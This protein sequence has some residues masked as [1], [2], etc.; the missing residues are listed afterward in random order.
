M[1]IDKVQSQLNKEDHFVFRAYDV[2]NNVMHYEFEWMTIKNEEDEILGIIFQS[3]IYKHN[4]EKWPPELDFEQ[5]LLIM[6]YIKVKD[7]NGG[8]IYLYDFV[9]V[10]QRKYGIEYIG[11]VLFNDGGCPYACDVENMFVEGEKYSSAYF[12]NSNN[13]FERV[14]NYYENQELRGKH[15]YFN[16]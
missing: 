16:V 3:D 5:Q 9:K 7:K 12:D 6:E 1:P 15:K 13:I 8:K 11:I 4:F 2:L 14:G 10:H